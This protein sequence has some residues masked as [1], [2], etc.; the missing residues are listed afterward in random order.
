MPES[1]RTN[2]PSALRRIANTIRLTG[3]ISFWFQ[4]VLAVVS[5]LILLFAIVLSPKN[6]GSN[7]P[8]SGGGAFLSVCALFT[9]YFTIYQAFSY[10]RIAKKLLDPD[11]N[12]RPKKADTM[13]II[14]KTL[15]A[16]L[17]GLMLA[18]CGAEAIA[19]ILLGRSIAVGQGIAIL[20]PQ[21]LQ[22]IIQPLDIFV[23]LANTHSITAHFGAMVAS[24]WLM[25]RLN[26][27]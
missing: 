24:L 25:D 21:T 2:L 4:V 20:N 9:L 7:S 22:N 18:I 12:F 8:A 27:Q 16:N 23:V 17:V 14:K 19:G 5:S 6:P 11:P 1:E 15:L 10:T 26:K 13:G 3:W